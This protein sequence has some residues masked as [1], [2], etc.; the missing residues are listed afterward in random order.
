MDLAKLRTV[1]L[2]NQEGILMTVSLLFRRAVGV[3]PTPLTRA[4]PP[5]D[6]LCKA[7]TGSL[8]DGDSSSSRA[9]Q[10]WRF[11]GM[12]ISDG[13]S[14][15]SR[16]VSSP[17][18]SSDSQPAPPTAFLPSAYSRTESAE[19][20]EVEAALQ[21]D[22]SESHD[23]VGD[24]LVNDPIYG[25]RAEASGL[26]VPPKPLCERLRTP[27]CDDELEELLAEVEMGISDAAP[28]ARDGRVG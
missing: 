3:K 6:P 24:F 20:V 1:E 15:S 10:K 12:A 13:D 28:L 16:A 4:L 5:T 18:S 8:D 9:S 21:P 11:S 27:A 14:Q 25:R 23:I 2:Q 26:E 17:A 7:F 19:A 22:A